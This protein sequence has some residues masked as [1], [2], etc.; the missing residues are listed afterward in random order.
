MPFPL[1]H[2]W[3]PGGTPGR[4]GYVDAKAKGIVEECGQTKLQHQ[5]SVPDQNKLYIDLLT[6][7]E[8]VKLLQQREHSRRLSLVRTKLEEAKHWFFHAEDE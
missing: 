1:G 7:L 5:S 3:R 2:S 8:Q 6:L 4:C